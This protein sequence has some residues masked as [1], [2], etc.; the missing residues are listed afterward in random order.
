[1]TSIP[2]PA[3]SQAAFAGVDFASY[4]PFTGLQSIFDAYDRAHENG[5]P[6]RV[7]FLGCLP[8]VPGRPVIF[9]SKL[10]IDGDGVPAEGSTEDGK[11]LDP[12]SGQRGT[13]YDIEGVAL[14][15]EQHPYFVLPLRA[16]RAV[17]GLA[18]GDICAVVLNGCLTGAVCGDLGPSDKLGEGSIFLH[19]GLAAGGA[20]DP[21]TRR[22]AA[23]RCLRIRN[24]S[25][26][27]GVVV[28]AFPGSAIAL[29]RETAAEQIRLEAFRLFAAAGGNA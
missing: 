17:T 13:S 20:P 24:A 5:D 7:T 15:S 26:S 27:G 18:L 9:C 14:S 29:K 21:C 16:F 8:G 22:D 6:S 2:F 12:D 10:A 28:M 11:A 23:G 1:M 4:T 3:K 25:I 19:S